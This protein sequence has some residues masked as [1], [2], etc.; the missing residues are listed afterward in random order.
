MVAT[1]KSLLVAIGIDALIGFCC[2]LAFS[3]L[4]TRPTFKRY[5]APK[6]CARP[7]LLIFTQNGR[8]GNPRVGRF[9]RHVGCRHS[10]GFHSPCEGLKG[11]LGAVGFVSRCCYAVALHGATLV[12]Y[13]APILRVADSVDAWRRYLTEEQQPTRPRKISRRNP[14]AWLGPTYSYTEEEV[15]QVAGWDAVVYLRIL[16]WGVTRSS[17]YC[18]MPML[19]HAST[20]ACHTAPW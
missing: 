14:F 7:S 11:A 2:L 1:A 9:Y 19:Y 12:S 4:R 8:T 3:L 20:C 15:L 5:Y 6:R 13:Q 10:S 16:R 17:R 18:R